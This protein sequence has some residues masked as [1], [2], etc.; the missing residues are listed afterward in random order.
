[1]AGEKCLAR[2]IEAPAL[3]Q[4]AAI[5]KFEIRIFAGNRVE[6]P[7]NFRPSIF[8]SE[9]F[10]FAGKLGVVI[11]YARTLRVTGYNRCHQ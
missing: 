6:L 11:G 4:R 1:M 5:I 2:V 9:L 7:R 10:D 3:R 8:I